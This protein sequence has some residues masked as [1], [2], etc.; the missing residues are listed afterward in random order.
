MTAHCDSIFVVRCLCR[1]KPIIL[2]LAVFLC[3]CFCF[4]TLK[5]DKISFPT[6]FIILPFKFCFVFT[7]ICSVS[8]VPNCHC[9]R[10]YGCSQFNL[11]NS[12]NLPCKHKNPEMDQIVRRETERTRTWEQH[13]QKLAY[14]QCSVYRSVVGCC[15]V[16]VN[17]CYVWDARDCFEECSKPKSN[18][19]RSKIGI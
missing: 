4:V 11:N 5:F 7:I 6:L 18:G 17:V 12:E 9:Q 19:K 1:R 2:L 10:F 8:S 14:L 13:Q 3:V 16:S 15:L